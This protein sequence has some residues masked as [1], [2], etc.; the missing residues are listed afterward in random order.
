MK[1]RKRIIVLIVSTSIS[2]TAWADPDANDIVAAAE[3]RRNDW[4]FE[5][6]YEPYEPNIQPNARGYRLPLN[7]TD[8]ANYEQVS[9]HLNLA[10]AQ[11]LIQQ[12][13]FAII[14]RPFPWWDKC[15]HGVIAPY[16]YLG[17]ESIP[18]F[19]TTDTFL[20]LYHIQFDETLRAIEER[21]VIRDVNDL[22]VALLN[23]AL[24]LHGRLEGDL[25]EAAKRNIAYLSVGRRLIDPNASI[26]EIVREVVVSELTKIEAH[27]GLGPSD[28]FIYEE[29]YS[30]Y[31]PRGHYARSEALRRYFKTMMW[32][33]RMG[34]LLKGSERWGRDQE[35]LISAH[36]ARIQTLQGVLLATSLKN[37]KVG[38]RTGL[39]VWERL[40][41]VT[42]FYVGP[43]DD[44]T[45]YDYVWAVE[46]VFGRDFALG[47]IADEKNLF[48]LK[49]ELALLPSP[50][51]Y[52]GT[53]DVLVTRPVAPETLD[54]I[55]D[56]SKGMRLMGQRFVP[57]SYIFQHLVFP[58]VGS[59]QGNPK[60]RPFTAGIDGMGGLCRAYVRGLDLMA[61]LGSHEALKVLIEEGDTEYSHYWRRFGE[62]KDEV[63]SLT[64]SDWTVNLYSC[65]LHSLRALLQELPE[66]YPQFMSTQAWHRRQL[67][68]AL[69]SWSELRHDTVLYA[70]QSYG[71]AGGV[72]PPRKAPPPGYIEPVPVFWGRLLSLTRMTLRGLGELNILSPE[73]RQRLTRLEESLQRMLEIV[74]KELNNEHLSSQDDE[75]IK[76]LPSTLESMLAGIEHT[77]FQTILVAD[78]HTYP[79]EEQV[80]EEGVGRVDLI[81]VACPTPNGKAFLAAG[82]VFSYYEFKH[83]IADRLTDEMWQ[84]LLDSP[85]RPERPKWYVP[86]MRRG[87]GS[88]TNRPPRNEVNRPGPWR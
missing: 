54:K 20:H 5:K 25:K 79:A 39:Q 40:Y 66:G 77:S 26:P 74:A 2:A 60:R 44:L 21:E 70:K 43:S 1:V 57:D 4:T 68:A 64:C 17:G 22:T 51:I 87:D 72:P 46:H 84:P 63:D 80:V 88:Y 82:P 67:H 76:G 13:G 75:F 65:W 23:R 81:L 11:D 50:R 34:F 59:Y 52:G 6:Y 83:P 10:N 61:L 35:A 15:S 73:T 42:A 37:V 16:Q 28:I 32:Y 85:K 33:A 29:D 24:R 45:P 30:Q 56:K 69:A 41:R 49:R 48:A 38:S 27:S 55:L 9:S 62:L 19:V 3:K 31:V 8:I 71:A 78:V 7:L 53:G 58:G 86:L 14:E 12:N 47:D 36:N 18:F